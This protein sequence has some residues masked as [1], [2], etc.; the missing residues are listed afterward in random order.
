MGTV[1]VS[2]DIPD[3][4]RRRSVAKA[5]LRMG[6]RVQYSV[7]LVH[8]ATSDDIAK[9]LSPLLEP[10]EDDVRIH[11]LCASCLEKSWLLGLAKSPEG[12]AFPIL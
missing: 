9:T 1:L 10:K 4:S 11:P 7:F 2:Y 3:D 12:R 6:K 5:L 8:R